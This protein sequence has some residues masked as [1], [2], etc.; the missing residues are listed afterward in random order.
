MEKISNYS[1]K[2]YR[3]IKVI[4]TLLY[5]VYSTVVFAA[6]SSFEQLQQQPVN[7]TGQVKSVEGITLPGVNVLI[8]G[9]SI[10][11]ISDNDG[12]YSIQQVDPNATLVFSYIGFLTQ[13]VGVNAKN[14]INVTLIEDIQSLDEVVIV[15]YG[16]Q[17]KRDLTGSIARVSGEEI[18]QPSVASFDQM[19]Q[20]KVA[21]VQISQTSGAPGGNVNVLVRGISSITGGNQPLYV[22]DGFPIGAGGGGSDMMSFGGNTFSSSGMANNIQ[23]RVNPLTAI[24]PA[25]IES[26]EILKDA[27]ATAIYGSRGANGVVIITTKRGK[28]G[29]ASVSVDATFGIQE[30]AH[31]LEMMNAQQFAEFVADGRDNAW[32]YAGGQASDPN[33][34]R[35]ASTRVKPEFRDPSSI[36]QNTDWQ[37]LIFQLAPVQDYKVSVDGGTDKIRYFVSGGYMKQEGIIIGT[38]YDRFSVRSNID[39]QLSDKFKIG[40]YISGSYTYGKY[41]N[42]EGHLGLRGVLS[43]ALASSPTIPVRDENGEYVSELLDPMGVPVENPLFILENFEDNR[44]SGGLLVNNF[45]EYDIMEGLK[46]KSTAGV[47]LTTN[48]I[49]LWKSSHLGSWGSM[50]SPATAGVTKIESLNWLNENTLNYKKMFG[51]HSLDALLGF[52][53]QKDRYDRLSAGATDFPTDYIT[54]LT[55]GTI[56]AGTHMVSEWSMM[57]LLSRVNYAYARKYLVTATVRRDGSSKFGANNKWGTFPSFSVGYNISE[58]PFM[59]QLSFISNWK[60]RASYGIAGNSLNENYAHIGLISSTNYVEN[61]NLKP[62]LAPNSLSND[63]LTWEKTKQTNIGMDLGLFQDRISVTADIYKN[64]KTDLLLAVQLPASSGFRSS[65]QNIGEIENKGIEL[66][67]FTKNVNNRDFQWESNVIFSA[68]RNKVLKLATEGERISNSAYQVTEVGQPIASFYLMHVT[69]IFQ[70]AN[71]VANSPVQHPKT[72][73][74]DLKFE[75]VD[76]DGKITTNDKKIVGNPWPDF[77]WGFNNTFSYKNLSLGIFLNGSQGGSTYFLAGETFINSAGVQNQLAMVDRRWKSEEDPGDGLIPRAIRSTHAYGF[78]STSRFLFDASYVRIKNVNLSYQLP[79]KIANRLKLAGCTIF[80]DVSNLHTFTDY[81]G[82]DPEASTAG[83][84]IV[85]SGIDNMTYPLARTYTIGLK[86]SF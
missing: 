4:V 16:T 54:Y 83:D 26:I 63:E 61:G 11:I 27:S 59:Q 77:T 43:S 7:V 18:I 36:T 68:N 8:K 17:L 51:D 42:T 74:G 81:P 10:G 62:G 9:T 80:A 32:V 2:N 75:D 45:V 55:G 14:V 29:K 37:D 85:N 28:S 60:L 44:I 33:N 3:F 34:V 31:R 49:K 84:N 58:E 38:D 35:S 79:S 6:G 53:I 30:V 39:A 73:P 22:V 56:N 66:N 71:E 57:S 12:N 25:D 64:I 41:P 78:T 47:N 86:M 19:L 21:G 1:K 24:N 40:S 76:L 69:G 72:Q 65:T 67:V 82:F 23:S 50:T 48:E 52:T 5:F 46:L 15:G 70:N 20:G 13:E